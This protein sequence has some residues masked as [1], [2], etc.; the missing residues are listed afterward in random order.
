MDFEPATNLTYLH[1]ITSWRW[2]I[3]AKSNDNCL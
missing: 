1:K 3:L 2:S